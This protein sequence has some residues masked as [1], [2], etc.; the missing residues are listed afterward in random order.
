MPILI[1]L[2]IPE[3]SNVLFFAL[4]GFFAHSS[5]THEEFATSSSKAA[6]VHFER[7]F[8][9]KSLAGLL[10]ELKTSTRTTSLAEF[11]TWYLRRLLLISQHLYRNE[12]V[13]VPRY[14]VGENWSRSHGSQI[15]QKVPSNEFVTEK[16]GGTQL[17][18]AATDRMHKQQVSSRAA[19]ERS[20]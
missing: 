1:R 8:L 12:H 4:P 3:T 18:L 10:L 15:I 2:P 16:N 20:R 14:Y 17:W 9:R 5:S 19:I 7:K 6:A 11:P 13:V